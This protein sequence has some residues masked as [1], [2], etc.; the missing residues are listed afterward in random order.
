MTGIELSTSNAVFTEGGL[1][2]TQFTSAHGHNG[3]FV[4]GLRTEYPCCDPANS[5]GSDLVDG[6]SHIRDGYLAVVNQ[7]L[8]TACQ[9]ARKFECTINYLAT[10]VLHFHRTTL[11]GHH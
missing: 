7:Y 6:C 2:I 5:L 3:S 11:Q 9:H 10:Q 1:A 8:G 4:S